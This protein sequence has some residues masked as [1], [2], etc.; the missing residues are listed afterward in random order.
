M[1]CIA[2]RV[3]RKRAITIVAGCLVAA[4]VV[5]IAGFF[6]ARAFLPT[7]FGLVFVNEQAFPD[8]GFRAFVSEYIDV[9]HDGVI[10]FSE[11]D[12]VTAISFSNP[13][14]KEATPEILAT[15]PEQGPL[16][17]VGASVGAEAAG[18]SADEGGAESGDGSVDSSDGEGDGEEAAGEGDGGGS[19]SAISTV[20]SLSGIEYFPN[21]R[22]LE[23]VGVGVTWL[24]LGQFPYLE[25]VDCRDN[26]ILELD[27]SANTKLQ[28]LFCDPTVQISGLENAG[29]FC[30]E[31]PVTVEETA[32][33]SG[34]SNSAELSLNYDGFGRLYQAG[35]RS[36]YYDEEG[37]LAQSLVSGSS[38]GAAT[39]SAAGEDDPGIGRFDRT[40][41]WQT[42]DGAVS[43]MSRVF[44]GED[45]EDADM[46]SNLTFRA[47]GLLERASLA[48]PIAG[49]GTSAYRATLDFAYEGSAGKAETTAEGNSANEAA[50]SAD[51]TN[52]ASGSDNTAPDNTASDNASAETASSLTS[53]Y[54]IGVRETIS[55]NSAFGTESEA[56]VDLTSS[57]SYSDYRLAQIESK[58]PA[59]DSVTTF[60]AASFELSISVADAASSVAFSTTFDEDGLPMQTNGFSSY[61]C[62][63]N[64]YIVSAQLGGPELP[65]TLSVTME[66][67]YVKHVGPVWYKNLKPYLPSYVLVGG[68]PIDEMASFSYAVWSGPL[69]SSTDLPSYSLDAV[70]LEADPVLKALWS[71]TGIEA[72]VCSGKT[73]YRQNTS[74]LAKWVWHDVDGWIE[75]TYPLILPPA[76][77]QEQQPIQGEEGDMLPDEPQEGA[78]PGLVSTA[79]AAN[80]QDWFDGFLKSNEESGSL[81]QGSEQ[82]K[83]LAMMEFYDNLNVMLD[84]LIS[85]ITA[86]S[87]EQTLE[88]FLA[89][90]TA[91]EESRQEAIDAAMG[92]AEQ[93]I[94]ASFAGASTGAEL[95]KQRIQQII[96]MLER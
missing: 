65:P 89:D 19:G 75:K 8:D 80:W 32:S 45:I 3:M 50:D 95:T 81:T 83:T 22:S 79:T 86:V 70:F 15:S 71:T 91:W 39:D 42:E 34:H 92:E 14:E 1:L 62:D 4:I 58:G 84:D 13:A 21:L 33:I 69:H 74:S 16:Y 47:D 59:G 53:V 28:S 67:S 43:G 30:E 20:Q 64:G 46:V 88:A 76:P 90:Q 36:Y 85:G 93:G 31:L 26:E 57:F 61:V 63:M 78:I 56:P 5:A 49:R 66:M 68:G 60:D 41:T 27:I 29:M 10:D 11:K 23:C 55:E 24:N 38:A 82:E 54:P 7:F 25:F 17:V 73:L 18:L 40:Y 94:H 6:I 37:R 35:N 87:S 52:V 72:T 12:A 9:N 2:G 96:N 48:S 51:G 44:A 77:E